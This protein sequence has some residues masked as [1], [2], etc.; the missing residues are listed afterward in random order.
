MNILFLTMSRIFDLNQNGIYPDLLREFT[1]N[2][3]YVTV[4]A[5]AE[6]RFDENTNMTE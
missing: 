3:H 5:P 6:R 4:A 2:G 1:K